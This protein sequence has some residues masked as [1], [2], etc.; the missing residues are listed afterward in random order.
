MNPLVAMSQSAKTQ[1]G[2][3]ISCNCVTIMKQ[4]HFLRV[5]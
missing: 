3:T 2:S 4:K 1:F 5:K